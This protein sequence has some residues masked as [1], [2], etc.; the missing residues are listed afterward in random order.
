MF[1]NG[2]G[3]NLTH[4]PYLGGPKAVPPFSAERYR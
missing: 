3:V 1:K 4:I 2:A